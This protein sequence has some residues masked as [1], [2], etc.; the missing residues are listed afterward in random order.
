MSLI[1]I[2]ESILKKTSFSNTTA[3]ILAQFDRLKVERNIQVDRLRKVS[4][5][6]FS[7]NFHNTKCKQEKERL[8][9]LDAD[10]FSSD[11]ES[12]DDF[13]A[14]ELTYD[15]EDQIWISRW[16]PR[17]QKQLKNKLLEVKQM[18]QNA[19]AQLKVRAVLFLYGAKVTI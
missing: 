1:S 11:D 9:S 14:E 5:D 3:E 7:L 16:A 8:R 17:R 18:K 4:V 6:L 19:V 10:I 15:E 12:D 2:T 13:T